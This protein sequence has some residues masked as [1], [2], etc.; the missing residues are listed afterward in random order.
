[1][2]I[3]DHYREIEER[4]QAACAKANR[5]RSEITLI[6]VSKTKSI[7]AIRELY[8]L[9]QRDFGES[10]LQEAEPKIAE[11]PSDIK[12]HF[13]GTLQSNKA[14]RIG[15]LFSVIHTICKESQ[16]REF[17]KLPN[18]VEALI[19]VNIA[20]EEQ[21]SGIDPELLDDFKEKLLQYPNVHFRGLM[22][23]GPQQ[24]D[25]EAMRPFFH[26]LQKCNF[27]LGGEWLS[28]GMS[29]DFEVAIQEGATHIRVG[30]ALFG[31]R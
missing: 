23:I 4:I 20:K 18:Q 27:A 6:A 17:A 25:V 10:R 19:E 29:A 21:K 13:I 26:A 12:W 30:T 8:S 9:G 1:M 24:N 15:E 28:M 16:L 3:V 22:T 31:S 14:K 11:L 2:L 5:T 7:E